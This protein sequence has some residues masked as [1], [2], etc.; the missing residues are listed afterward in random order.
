MY[1]V[2]SP[3]C[4]ASSGSPARRHTYDKENEMPLPSFAVEGNLTADPEYRTTNSGKTV[5]SFRV[6]ANESKYDAA[7]GQYEQS[8]VCYLQCT[9]WPPL[10]DMMQA[11]ELAKGSPIVM[12]GRLESQQWQTEQGEPRSSLKYTVSALGFDLR[13]GTARFTKANA[14]A[15]NGGQMFGAYN[16]GAAYQGGASQQAT[17]PYA[18]PENDP[19]AGGGQTFGAGGDTQSTGGEEPEF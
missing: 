8:G 4:C 10:S 16:G 17:D 12:H 7:T 1:V 11:S 18:T 15:N 3:Y 14:N 6:A 9:A 13:R 5:A 2:H 19:W